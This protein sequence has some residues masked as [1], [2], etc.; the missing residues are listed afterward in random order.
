MLLFRTI[1]RGMRR[2]VHPRS[3]ESIRF[4]GRIAEE[5]TLSA[6]LIYFAVYCL[7]IIASMLVVS[8][9]N[10]SF[11]TTVT[12]VIACVNNIGPGLGAV[13]P[14][15]NF[16]DFSALSKLVLSFGMLAGR[17]EL[18]PVLLLFSPSTWRQ[19]MLYRR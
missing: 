6:C 7:I 2:M 13:G 5:E 14:T 10:H 15:G 18:F 4:E 3:V 1:K 8:I 9:D 19:G 16:A 17:L 12:A 11:E